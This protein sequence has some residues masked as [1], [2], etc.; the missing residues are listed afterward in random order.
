VFSKRRQ[1]DCSSCAPLLG[2]HP[3]VDEVKEHQT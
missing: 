3:F 1:I 2:K